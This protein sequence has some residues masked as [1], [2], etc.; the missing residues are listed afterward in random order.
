MVPTNKQYCLYSKLY[1]AIQDLTSPSSYFLNRER[2]AALG[3]TL[4]LASSAL[5]NLMM[6]RFEH[7]ETEVI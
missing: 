1:F 7:S 3:I 5:Q 6:S 4:I 2:S